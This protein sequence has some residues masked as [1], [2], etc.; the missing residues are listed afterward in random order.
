MADRSIRLVLSADSERAI[1]ALDEVGIRANIVGKQVEKSFGTS[2][3]T[4]AH[5]TGG[6]FSKVGTTLESW[7]VPFMGSL[8]KVGAKLEETHTKGH[9]ALSALSEAGKVTLMAGGAGVVALGAEALKFGEQMQK[10]TAG[11][12][13]GADIPIKSAEKI[14]S[15]FNGMSTSLSTTFKGTDI[16]GAY[17]PVAAQLSTVTGRALSASDAVKVMKASSDLAEASGTDLASSTAA[18]AGVL[19]VYKINAAGA[20]QASDILYQSAKLTGQGVGD[21]ATV[22]EKMAGRLGSATPSLADVGALMVDLYKQG[23]QGKQAISG[24]GTAVNGLL[25]PTSTQAK[26]IQQLGLHTTTSTGAF[27]GMSSM[28]DQLHDRFAKL[29]PAQ[30]D[31]AAKTLFGATA[32]QGMLQVVNAGPAAFNQSTSRPYGRGETA[33]RRRLRCDAR[34]GRQ[35]RARRRHHGCPGHVRCPPMPRYLLQD[36]G[37]ADRRT[38]SPPGCPRRLA[39][40]PERAAPPGRNRGV[41]YRVV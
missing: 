22:V 7:G 14:Q 28:L 20:G 39:R 30:Q 11:I 33:S 1:R 4:A 12:A 35:T 36:R 38:E 32:W 25:A 26:L 6:A 41:R 37:R 27:V 40:S 9:K 23:D 13:A 2:L 19:Q 16:A 24:V 3:E 15:A 8:D 34:E 5:K 10:S 17:A 31:A 18:L 21:V 29:T